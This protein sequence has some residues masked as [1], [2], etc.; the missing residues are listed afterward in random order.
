MVYTEQLAQYLAHAGWYEQVES[1]K[2]LSH[3]AASQKPM[4]RWLEWAT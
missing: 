1:P 3:R 4:P 2:D